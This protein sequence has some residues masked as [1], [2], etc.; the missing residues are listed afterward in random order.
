V[1]I[2][3]KSRVAIITGASGG[4]GS[5][6]AR[7]LAENSVDI[8]VHYYTSI[9]SAKKTVRQVHQAGSDAI[10]YKA[11]ISSPKDVESMIAECVS[12]FGRIDILVNNA[13]M[14][15]PPEFTITKPDWQLWKKMV[16]V[17]IMGILVCSHYCAPHLES[18]GGSIINIVM[19]YEP[20]GLGYIATKASGSVL[21]RGLA[22]ELAP[23]RANAV[24]PG[25]ID[26]WGMTQAELEKYSK[27]TLLKR[28]G[29]PLDIAK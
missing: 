5:E 27:S 10:M 15:P 23:I 18:T 13:S 29:C 28:V 16:H 20:G 8:L 21:T 14:H 24:S 26:T 7:V 25:A 2:V 1:E 9:E 17:N 6:T 22:R 3:L 12:K 11:D 19:D 4:I